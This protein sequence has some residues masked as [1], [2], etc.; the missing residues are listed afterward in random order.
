MIWEFPW[1]IIFGAWVTERV[2]LHLEFPGIGPRLQAPCMNS[3]VPR[4]YYLETTKPQ[5]QDFCLLPI[6]V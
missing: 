4:L 5:I 3:V 6:S 2:I 1:L